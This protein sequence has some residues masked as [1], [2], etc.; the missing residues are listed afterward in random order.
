MANSPSARKGDLTEGSIVK[1]LTLFA[2]PLIAGNIV[3]QLYNVADSVVVGNFVSSDALAA[4]GAS[5]PVMMCFN[6][7]F[8][9]LSM[10]AGILIAQCFGAKEQDKL[11]NAVNTAFTL[12]L[13]LGSVITVLGALFSRQMLIVMKTPANILADSTTYLSIIFYATVGNMIYNMGSGILRGMGDSRWPLLFLIFCSCMNVLLDLVFVIFLDMGVAG[14]AWATLISQYASAVLTVLRIHLG[15]Y[16]ARVQYRKLRVNKESFSQIMRLG[17]PSGIQEMAYSL[18]MMLVQS[19]S[20]GFGSDFIAANSIIMKVDGFAVM[21]MMG[22]GAAISTFVGQNMGANKLDRTKK[23]IKTAVLM[24]LGIGLVM[25]VIL[26]TVGH[27]F[28][29]AFTQSEPVLEIARN[30]LEFL[31]F[32]Y[33]IM[34]IG[35]VMGGAM[36]GA[37]A[38][39]APMVTS[40]LGLAARIPVAYFS[41]VVPHNYMG[42]FYAMAAAITVNCTLICLYYYKGNWREK[43]AVRSEAK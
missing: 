15:G 26:I 10:G 20:N 14:V 1:K 9:G 18:G 39:V 16:A 25:G 6:A 8:W 2:L 33:T 27:L 7:L 22:I 31:A 17:L 4:V 11:Q 13:I 36:R 43:A 38:A 32:L 5:F 37:G 3:S 42:I 19:F 34:G 30:G 40:L 23:G 24:V 35:A 29:R 41:A 12:T 21:P 28:L